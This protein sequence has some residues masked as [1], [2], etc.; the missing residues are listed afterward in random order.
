MQD[1]FDSIFPPSL[2]QYTIRE[3]YAIVTGHIKGALYH[4]RLNTQLVKKDY[5][6]KDPN[7]DGY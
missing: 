2:Y 5:L 4:C 7:D 6:F 3:D 1:K